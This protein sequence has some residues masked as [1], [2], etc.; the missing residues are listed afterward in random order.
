VVDEAAFFFFFFFVLSFWILC[1]S[2]ALDP[3][4]PKLLASESDKESASPK[5][6]SIRCAEDSR[7]S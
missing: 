6:L 5:R 1:C 2:D 3:I 7:P 4:E